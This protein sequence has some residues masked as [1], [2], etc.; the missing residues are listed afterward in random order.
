MFLESLKSYAPIILGV[1]FFGY[2]FY[3]SKAIKKLI[4]QLKAKNAQIIDVRSSNEFQYSNN[5][6]SINIPVSEINEKLSQINSGVPIIVC[7]ATGTRSSMAKR[8]LSTKGYEV[9]NAGN[10]QNT[11]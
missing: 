6:D 10:W 3:K 7:C 2:R 1:A 11:L 4:P 5:P 9:Y 8:L